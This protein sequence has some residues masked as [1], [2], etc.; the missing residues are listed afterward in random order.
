[1]RKVEIFPLNTIWRLIHEEKEIDI[2]APVPGSVFE[3]LIKNSIIKDPF[4]GEN[5]HEVSWVYNSDWIY[6]TEFDVTEDFLDHSHILLR[7]KGLDTISDVYLNGKL[8]GATQNMFI[9]HDFEVKHLLKRETNVL[10]VK[11]RSP[12]KTA[13]EETKNHG[14]PL[15]TGMDSLL[16]APYL[17][18][19]QYSF[20]WDWGPKL[21]D[22]GFFQSL[23][24]IGFN[25]LKIESVYP[26]QTFVYNKNPLN[27][28]DPE[29]I[30]T[31]KI[32]SVK[33]QIQI[34]ITS[35]IENLESLGCSIKTI[36]TTPNSQKFSKTVPLKTKKQELELDVDDPQLWWSHDLGHPNLHKLE[37]SITNE[38]IIDSLTQKIGIRDIRLVRTPDKWGETFYFLLNG[39][40]VFA[41]GANWIPVDSFIPRGK[42]LGLYQLNLNYAK[43][44]NMNFIRVWGGGIYEDNSFYELCDELGILVWQDFPFACSIYPYN[45]DFIENVKKE[46]VQ[47]IKRLRHH[48]SLALW[49][50][51][52]EIEMLWIAEITQ[53]QILNAE[54]IPAYAKG[55]LPEVK[56]QKITSYENGYVKIF[57][58][59]FP[60]LIE[61]FDPNRSYWST[62][63]SNET[64]HDTVDYMH[65][66]DP[67][68]G[69]SHFWAVWH[70]GKP[71]KAYRKFD[72]RFMSE[73]GFESF[74]SMKTIETFCP[75]EQF[76]MHS[77]IMEN[78]QK[79]S[80]G[81]QKIKRYMK[82]R[83]SF[84][85]SFEK[86][87]ILSQITQAEAIEYGVEYWR[88]KRNNFRCM[89]ALYWQLNDCWPVASW[90]SLDYYGRWK[91]LHYFAK[92]F[93]QPLFPSV[94]EE[95]DRVEFWIT[96]DFNYSREGTINWKILNSQDSLLL[97]DSHNFKVAPCS[98]VMVQ[99]I[100]VSE[101][102][103]N[104]EQLNNNIIFYSLNEENV[105]FKG[106]RLFSHP[107]YFNLNNPKLSLVIKAI[108]TS[109]NSYKMEIYA[110]H[111]ALYVYIESDLVDFIASDNF[112]SMEPEESRKIVLTTLKTPVSEN[113]RS[114]EVINSF[115]VK[116][117]Y[118][119]I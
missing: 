103:E 87:V 92:R 45:E 20:G 100:D 12:T 43:E 60:E 77:P 66:N 17:R 13:F 21:P 19:A 82:K 14:D 93:Y 18:K 6:T 55:N 50:G 47:N 89:G 31:I 85:E 86:Q 119:L 108:D 78:H 69:D 62:S 65:S 80:A 88:R 59:L 76:E 27:I 99:D 15:T 83:F 117:L 1:M 23:E 3:A 46:A 91:A 11:F 48:P 7:F 110:K 74:P 10:R 79:N 34:E 22:I 104:D 53:S 105:E 39:V 64:T 51:N 111:I 40:P 73:F 61:R 102:N 5:E 49:C 26:L 95:K 112:F 118:D 36:L 72:S 29:E 90:S 98:S 4:Y 16:G 52:N 44:A 9:I 41:K 75:P 71:F 96:N 37:I 63:P 107:K 67:E 35:N 24:L 101:I 81:N 38:E 56:R 28:V 106:F 70:G 30:S 97:A 109:E 94:K 84:P 32:E 25:D 54:D 68:R 116:S 2:I 42:R 57:K 8:L 113:K 58:K 115:T 33:I 114:I